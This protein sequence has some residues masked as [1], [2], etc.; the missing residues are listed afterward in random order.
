MDWTSKQL[1]L[2]T[3]LADRLKKNKEDRK[4]LAEKLVK[5]F[6]ASEKAHAKKILEEEKKAE[7]RKVIEKKLGKDVAEALEEELKEAEK[8]SEPAVEVKPAAPAKA[9]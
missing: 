3:T 1:G 6:L 9:A 7:R 8:K 2:D 5:D 4:K